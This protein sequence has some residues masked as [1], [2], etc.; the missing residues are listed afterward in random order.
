MKTLLG[1]VRHALAAPGLSRRVSL[2][3]GGLLLLPLLALAAQKEE[4]AITL[5][6]K[7][8]QDE[9]LKYRYKM[10]MEM[11]LPAAAQSGPVSMDMDFLYR[12]KTLKITPEGSA[13]VKV[14]ILDKKMSVNGQ[15]NEAAMDIPPVTYTYDTLGNIKSV[16]GLPQTEPVGKMMN[17]MFNQNG[18]QMQ[19]VFLPKQ[20]VR[21]G[22]KW[23]SPFKMPGITEEAKA[24]SE[25]VKIEKVGRYR[26]ALIRTQILVPMKMMMDSMGQP[27][28][29]A[30][31]VMMKI[32]GTTN[33]TY[34]TNFAI[35]EGQAVR[36][37][38][39]A[40]YDME[41]QMNGAAAGAAG[42]EPLKMG[43]KMLIEMNR[44]D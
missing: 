18:A 38:G 32:T 10:K 37:K 3:S 23:E 20:A 16:K 42:Q 43:G 19:M 15:P 21:V 26:T 5:R 9:V 4:P 40:E 17:S 6:M 13:E 35:E 22:D 1:S 27:T 28:D 44:A 14:T 36:A 30:E 11:E 39:E 34:E 31:E 24:K 25:F 2:W 33:T 7:F 8:K 12:Y 29:K 41:M